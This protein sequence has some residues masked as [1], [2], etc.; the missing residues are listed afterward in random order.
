MPLL[1]VYSFCHETYNAKLYIFLIS[2]LVSRLSVDFYYIGNVQIEALYLIVTM[3]IIGGKY[4]SLPL[5]VFSN[6]LTKIDI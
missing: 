1:Q 6:I 2:C 5:Y 3:G 4:C